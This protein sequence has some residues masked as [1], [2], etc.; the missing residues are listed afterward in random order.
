M[1]FNKAAEASR[2]ENVSAQQDSEAVRHEELD[3]KIKLLAGGIVNAL[4]ETVAPAEKKDATVADKE[5]VSTDLQ[6]LVNR[7]NGAAPNKGS[8]SD[9][10]DGGLPAWL[11]KTFGPQS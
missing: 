10:E 6:A 11:K 8:S 5:A 2:Q 9:R 1:D 3:T 4:Q 7:L